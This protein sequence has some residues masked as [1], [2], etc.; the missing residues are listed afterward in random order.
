MLTTMYG[1]LS[2]ASVLSTRIC[3]SVS[4]D[5][6]TL[7]L[8]PSRTSRLSL[9]TIRETSRSYRAFTVDERRS[10]LAAATINTAPMRIHAARPPLTK[11][12]APFPAMVVSSSLQGLR[13]LDPSLVQ[14]YQHARRQVRRDRAE[15][16][17]ARPDC[18]RKHI[19]R[20]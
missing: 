16:L 4:V 8:M 19:R 9:N 20:I 6:P 5:A 13:A 10:T 11:N 18:A 14:I 17:R 2:A 15:V 7:R 12:P 3:F 1:R